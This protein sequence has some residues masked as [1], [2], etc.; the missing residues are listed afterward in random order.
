MAGFAASVTRLLSGAIRSG[1]SGRP[2]SGVDGRRGAGLPALAAAVLALLLAGGAPA[3]ADIYLHYHDDGSQITIDGSGSLE[4]APLDLDTSTAAPIDR[5]DMGRFRSYG[6]AKKSAL[7]G[8]YRF[9]SLDVKGTS[10]YTGQGILRGNPT[11]SGYSSNF[12]TLINRGVGVSSHSIWIDRDHIQGRKWTKKGNEPTVYHPGRYILNDGRATLSGTLSSRFGDDDFHMEFHFAG[13][14]VILSTRHPDTP[15]IPDD[16]AAAGG[17]REVALSW[18]ARSDATGWQVRYRAAGAAWGA[19]TDIS[20]SGAA[21]AGHTVTGLTNGVAYDF[22][23]RAVNGS[24]IGAASD[25]AT[26]TPLGPPGAPTGLAAT[27]SNGSVGLTWNLPTDAGNI[28]KLQVRWKPVIFLPFTDGDV[29]ADLAA[30]ATRTRSTRVANGAAYLFELRAVNDRGVSPTA[31]VTATPQR[32]VPVAP[33]G[34]AATAGVG[35]VTLSWD[36]SPDATLTGYELRYTS[37][38]SFAD[39]DAWS[40]IAGSGSTTASH[41]LTGLESRGIWR[42]QVRAVNT[43]G[44]SAAS[45]EAS[46]ALNDLA[47]FFGAATVADR[48]YTQRSAIPALTLPEAT[49]GDSPLAYTLTPD[50]PAGLALDGATRTV[51]GTPTAAQAATTYSWTATDA[52]GDA[53]TLTFAIAVEADASPSFGAATIADRGYELH[54]AIAPLSLPQASGGNGALAYSLA[55]DLPP[56]L[57][58]DADT[59]TVSGTPT[60]AHAATSYTWTVTDAD[61]DRATLSFAIAATYGRPAPPTGL[62]VQPNDGQATLS[63]SD[64]GDGNIAGY[65]VRY[66]QGAV[67]ANGDAWTDIAGGG[68]ATTGHTVTGLQ[69]GAEYIFQ[70][71]AVASD[72]ESGP[73]A[74]VTATP[75]APP[76][77]PAGVTATPGAGQATLAGTALSPVTSWQYRQ[78][79]GEGAWGAWTDIAGSGAGTVSHVVTGLADR[80]AYGFQLRAVLTRV[81]GAASDEATATPRQ[82]VGFAGSVGN[83]T[84]REYQP[85]EPLV[86]PEGRGGIL[87]LSYAFAPAPPAGLTIDLDTRTISGKLAEE[88]EETT[89]NWMVTD[90]D[91]DAATLTFTMDSHYRGAAK[92]TGFTAT[93]GDGQ[94]TV[95]WD[96]IGDPNITLNLLYWRKGSVATGAPPLQLNPDT[97]SHTFT[98]LDNGD[99]YAFQLFPIGPHAGV[100][101]DTVTATPNA[102]P[103]KPAAIAAVAGDGEAVLEWSAISGVTDWQVQQREGAGAWGD[104]RDID[105]SSDATT[106]HTVTGL[107]NGAAY[108]FRVRARLTGVPGAASD[109]ATATPTANSAPGFGLAAIANRDFELHY[110]IAAVTL[111]QASG[112]NGTLAY[113]LSPDL[114]AGLAL[115]AATRTVSGTPTAAQAATS[116]S[117]TATDA[118]GDT[119]ALTFT[120]AATYGRPLQPAGLAAEAYDGRVTLSWSDPG[121]GNIAGYRL[122]YK[123]GAAFTDGDAWTDIAGSGAATVSHTVTSLQNNSRYVFQIR[124]VA[125]SDESPPSDIV[126]TVP[127]PRPAKPAG[128]SASVGNA[129]VTL[130]WS[131]P[132]DA[133]ITRYELRHTSTASFGPNDAWSAIPGSGAATVGREVAGLVNDV[134]RR[135][136]IRAVNAVGPGPA[137]DEVEAT[138]QDLAPAFGANPDVTISAEQLRPV[139]ESLPQATGGDGALTYS[140]TPALPAGLTFDSA[141]H[142]VTG[143]PTATQ[144]ATAYSFAATDADGDS[145]TAT[146]TIQVE[147]KGP[148]LP[149]NITATPGDGQVTLSWDRIEDDLLSG[150]SILYQKGSII[151]WDK[152]YNLINVSIKVTSYTATGLDN[153]DQYIFRVCQFYFDFT[154]LCLNTI[155]ATPS[156][157]P[158]QPGG[159]AAA[160]GDGRVALSWNA[161]ATASR[162]DYRQQAGGGAFG[163]WQAIP[164]SGGASTG[165]LITGLTNGT[166]YGFQIRA[167]TGH[168]AMAVSGTVSATPA[169][170]PP[171]AVTSLAATAS[172]GAVGLTWSLPTNTDDIDKLQVRWKQSSALPFTASDSWT[173]LAADATRAQATG[174]TDGAAYTFAVRAVNGEGAGDAATVAAT[175]ASR[176]PAAPTGLV[177]TAGLGAVTLAWDD[178]LD[179]TVTGY[180]LR[181]TDA[182]SFG[183]NDA[184]SAISGSGSTTA[185]HRVTGLDIR[186]V[187]RFQLRAVNGSGQGASAE[188]SVALRDLTPSFGAATIADRTYTQGV[189]IAALALPAATGGDGAASYALTPALPTGLALDMATRTVSGTPTALQAATSYSWTATDADGDAAALTFTLAVETDTA[190]SFGDA[191]VADRTFTQGVA[192][193]ALTLPEATGGNGALTYALTPDLPDGLALDAATRTVSGT[194]TTLQTAT[195]YTWTVTDAEGDSVSLGFAIAVEADAAPSFGD[196]AVADLTVTQGAVMTALTL[197][198]ATGGNGALSYALTPDLPDGLAFDAA[199]RTV[200]GTPTTLQTATNYSWTVTDAEGDTA[201]LGFAIAVEADTAPSFGDAAVADLT[202]TQGVAIAALTLPEATG[203]NGALSYA[204][205]P[206]LPD[207]LALDAATRT[208]SGTPTTL[209]TATSWSWTVTDAEGDTA[210]LGFAMTVEADVAPSFGDAAVA[211][212]SYAQDAAIAAFILPEATGGN[213]ALSYALTP[214]LPDGLAL[215]AATRA[216]S[217]TPTT[218][219]AATSYSWTV[220][221]ADGDTAS[222]SFTIAVEADVAPSFG[223]AAVADLTFTQGVAITAFAL[224]EA[225]GGNGALDHALTPDLPGGLALDA[226]TQ[227]VSGTPTALQTATSYSW[228]AT[229]ADGDAATLAFAIAVEANVTPSFGSATVADRDYELHYAIAPLSLPQASGG[230][231]ALA[232]SLSP[233]LPAGLA[234]DADTRTVSGAPTAAQAATSYTWTAT[235]AEGDTA[236]LSFAIAAT[237]GR[238]AP[239]VGL[240]VQPNDGG[241]AL[242]W[243]DP[244][245]ANIAGYRLRY[246][247]GTVF[248]DSDAWSDIVGSGAATT[249][250]SVTGLQNGAE[251]VFQ[252]RAV[253]SGGESAPSAALTA[254]PNAPPAKPTAIAAVAGDGEALLEWSA[255]SGV[256]D[257]Q[258]QQREGAGAWGDWQDIDASSDATTRHVVTGLTN[259]VAYGFR[260]RARL[261]RVPGAASDEATATPTADPAPGF[262]IA[263]I[264][265]RDFELHYPIAAVT[266]PAALGGNGPLG[267]SLSPAPPAGL[268]LD[269]ATRTISGTPTVA[270]TATSYSWT[271]TDADGDTATLTFTVAATYGRPLPPA[272]LAAEA[273]DGRAV[274]SWNDPGDG[275]ITGYRLRYKKGAAFTTSDAWTDIAGSGPSTVSHTVASLDNGAQY[276]FQVRAVA[277]SGE[278]PPSDIVTTA[279]NPRPAKPAGLSAAV[280]NAQVTLAWSNPSDTTITRYELRH[281]SAASFGPNDA[282]SAIPGSG[283]GTVGREVA[284]LVNDV[285][286]RFQI[287]A[288]NAVGP[289]PASDEVAATPQDLAPAFA[290]NP[291]LSIAAEQYR[292]VDESLPQASGGDGA[293]TYS[294]TPDLPAGLTFDSAAHRIVGAPAAT[295]AATAYSFAATDADGDSATA[296]V[297]IQVAYNGPPAPT[298]FTATPGD[299][300]VTLSWE[301]LADSNLTSYYVVYRKGST[302]Q[303]SGVVYKFIDPET[304]HTVTGLDNGDI[305]A[306]QLFQSLRPGFESL[307]SDVVTATPGAAPGQ[308]G[309]FVATAG[310]GRVRLSWNAISTA[311]RWDYRYQAAGGAFGAWRAI[312]GSG[313][314]STG[315]LVTGL[316]NGTAYGFQIRAVSGHTATVVSGTVSATPAAGPPGAVTSLAATASAGAVGLTWSLPTNTDDID[317]LQLR[318]K[319][320]SA[321]PFTASDSWS[322][323]AADAT[324]AQATGLTDGAA[325]TFAVRAVNGEGA[326]DAATVAATPASRAPAAPTGLVATA[327]LGAVT[328]AWDDPLDPTVT[329]YELRYTDAASFGAN[330]AW[331]AI[332]GS[333]STTA[334]H[335]VTGLDIRTVWRFQ[336]RAVNGSGAGA[337]AEASAA[338]RDLTPSFGAATVA[339]RTYTQGVAIAALA[340]P[341]ASG[342]DGA[343]S[344]ALTPALPAGLALDMAAR[345]VS[346][347]PT[348]AQAATSYSWTATDADGDAAA[349]TFTLAAE[350]DTAPSFASAAIAD[351]SYRQGVA[352]TALALPEATGGNGTL[353]YALTP[354]LPDGLAFDAATRTV[355]GAPTALQAATSYSWTVTDA[356]G[357]TVSL[358]FTI[359]VETET[360]PSFG[361]VTVADRSYAKDVAIAAFVLPE[362]GGGNGPLTYSLTPDL[363]AGLALDAATRTVSGTPTALQASA[364]WSWTVTDADGDTAAL[365]FALA[366]ESDTAPTFGDA[367]VADRTFKQG[368][369][370]TAFVLPE[371]TGGNGALDY[372][373]T[374]DLP[375]GLA[376]DAATRTVS[377]TPTAVQAATS[378]SW[379]V[380]D[381]DGDTASLGFAMTVEADTAPTFGDA[382]VADRSYTQGTAIA[383]LTLP[384]ATGG[385]GALSYALTPALPAGL[386]LDMATR[387][388][389]GT[390]TA[391]LAAT[392]YSWTATDAD[393]DAASLGF[394]IEV[395]AAAGGSAERQA[396][397]KSLAGLA[398]KTLGE[399]RATIGQRLT[400]APGASSLTV[401]GRRIEFGAAGQPAAFDDDRRVSWEEL[402]RDSAFEMSFGEAGSGLEMTAWGRGGLM[403]FE[404]EQAGIDHRSRM[405]TGWLGMDARVGDGLLMGFALSRSAG[406]TEASDGA[407]FTTALSA[408]WPYAQLKLASGAE[409][410][411]VLGAGNGSVDYRPAEGVGETEAL[412]MRLA[413]AGGRQ[414]LADV[415]A[416]GLALEAD[417]GFV[418][419]ETG[420]SARS[421][422]GGHEVQVWRA[423]ASLEAEHEGWGLGGGALAPF[424]S[425]AWRGDG[426]D[427]REGSGVEAGFG[428]RLSAPGSRF[429]LEA[430]GRHLALSSEAGYG[431]TG[432]SLTAGLEPAADGAG[433]SWSASLATGVRADGAAMLA[434]DL[435]YDEAG[436][437]ADEDRMALELEARYGFRLPAAHGLLSPLLRLSEEEGVRRKLEAGLAFQAARG[438]VDLELTGGHETRSGAADNNRF[439]LD[440][441]LGF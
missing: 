13:Q 62:A 23:V 158:G 27:V 134:A 236:T 424:G 421:V 105:A 119:A 21:T 136:Q 282:W 412:E 81:P 208:V 76:P 121:D 356:D 31:T 54:Y 392:S 271:A 175:P 209:Q 423:R 262:G 165:H 309:G 265:N 113:S 145:V 104:W 143:A 365:T 91:G 217:G 416:L 330:D 2:S 360:A 47:P 432:A 202:L 79:Q 70:I 430:E 126:T 177:A 407:G 102:P 140:F 361:T 286:R 189:A 339:D 377:G 328:L 129:Q 28:D 90:A 60:A 65:R 258:V 355:S 188:A 135:F 106:R 167:V 426:G 69:N 180:E 408:A 285:A 435:D 72:G 89:Y 194:P 115:D 184:W 172:T 398:A 75:N 130:A 352:I 147:Y 415:G 19:W 318:W 277:S 100:R 64:P 244:G 295:Q 92:P 169:A 46:V 253:A 185:G 219:Q 302:I 327:G 314:A 434:D 419:L 382:A 51:S 422:I 301:H 370:I 268:A 114:P 223:D 429:A 229:D 171:G 337:S 155:T 201:S 11:I 137:S 351:R 298:N 406:E 344:Y 53:A 93:P 118:D 224:P 437:G 33:T 239:P 390:P 332:S 345:T 71:R 66:K 348:A 164:G 347:T 178:P 290:A 5:V 10:S 45:A 73:S 259:S 157:A 96:D 394:S 83:R 80:T 59:R 321:L 284:G 43:S 221:D 39:G 349:L 440:L 15:S 148:P 44:A 211:D 372:A 139:T 16:F 61:G 310:D 276:A 237:Y 240:T 306:F 168:T 269:T 103:A 84:L 17:D 308:P 182:A 7:F 376:L 181:Y 246:K 232:Y 216:V 193:A 120:I 200:S 375:A 275:N 260:V 420:G 222:L 251:Y 374:P 402:R 249:G 94:V 303:G 371:A 391:A 396:F 197:P 195:S 385:N 400:A 307:T 49:A 231:G 213:G 29:W 228:T 156:V 235:D 395:L 50:L 362:A 199:T 281:T 207:G 292:S 116:Y 186:T 417:A 399:A 257:W 418:T 154:P 146:V 176:A 24:R 159:F 99:Q 174:L 294:F 369:A 67:F 403:R 313:G 190:P 288:V 283:A 334:G 160:A 388:V 218:L 312:P 38:A 414:P 151:D 212:R 425:L 88:L 48:N 68:A 166:A 338:L 170:G 107:T 280:G 256:T 354:D 248:T 305:Y 411:T 1:I 144:A 329:G 6:L 401:A 299:G 173:D 279:P 384:A 98:G 304:S 331:S 86:L 179:P 250:H 63:W 57:A 18:A 210:S 97:T 8:Y 324:R 42:F 187:W 149:A 438:R 30:N 333:G 112:G 124:A 315:H 198:E 441:R 264:A 291:D 387:T 316:A 52:D 183:A 326:G 323:L 230:N 77:K 252:L 366:V 319:Q 234:L 431:G 428:A 150:Y 214:D 22:Q 162:W 87:P 82:D 267:Y 192:I 138:P 353:D 37:A 26:A 20:G 346:G 25:E 389:S 127:N 261:T 203:G 122:R 427:W 110:P 393:G 215:D 108:G 278:S 191:A 220:T 56:G 245:D 32:R 206:D 133:T 270:Q 101:T 225:T 226:A 125:S 41:T 153:G 36:E 242:S 161:I 85:M 293:L 373:L 287:R 205:T 320:S 238:P 78:R 378:W 117:W 142:R 357:D 95:V 363:P 381:A 359:A 55:P 322:D 74:A 243:S 380:T 439:R 263:A 413:S 35:E 3:R 255:I 272:G 123:Q 410:W 405:E 297:T 233:D 131:D 386:A 343:A 404:A 34:L 12:I 163:P 409:V 196:A 141:A 4:L 341:A 289:G 128:L 40:A 383:A 364:T 379:T 152:A 273:Y 433:L 9:P 227:T 317:K 367:A 132:S 358:G 58:L 14:K 296:T 111:P 368:E 342:G 336:L 109:E 335:T 300:Q 241:A 266:L 254:T 311:S 340:L 397:A 325:Y 204:L 350:A 436:F 274:L 247:Q